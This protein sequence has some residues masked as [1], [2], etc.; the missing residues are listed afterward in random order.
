MTTR[1]SPSSGK[2][3]PAPSRL[4]RGEV[5]RLQQELAREVAVRD[6]LFEMGRSLRR[7]SQDLMRSI[8]AGSA[9]M[10]ALEKLE[11][12][13]R[14]FLAEPGDLSLGDEA[15]QEYAEARLLWAIRQGFELPSAKELGLRAGPYL[16]GLADVVGEVRRLTLEE[17]A[18]GEVPRA[19][20]RLRLMEELYHTLM[21]FEAP[22]GV[23][24]LKPKQDSARALV[25]RTRSDVVLA[26]VLSR[27]GA[28][29]ALGVPRREEQD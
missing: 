11:A 20:E 22:R 4:P 1:R 18:R 12:Q 2:G 23:L 6:R 26:R 19:E 3:G 27:A 24:A 10:S 7:A 21:Q 25:E 29:L 16:G 14:R 9:S 15:L 17:L 28:G 5:A 13:A 8:H